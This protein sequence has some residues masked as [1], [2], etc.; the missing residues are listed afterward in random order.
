[1]KH[2]VGIASLVVACTANAGTE[3]W[4]KLP[5]LPEPNGGFMCAE[6]AGKVVVVGGTN[7]VNDEKRW[8]PV[9]NVFDPVAM[10]WTSLPSL[11]Q[12]LAHA[13]VGT[14][15]ERLVIAGGTT[16][17]APFTESVQFMPGNAVSQGKPGMAT[18]AVGAA[19]G[20]IGDEMIVV[21]GCDNIANLAAL[22]REAFA[23]NLRTGVERALPAYPAGPLG[24]TASVVN[25]DEVFVFGGAS[26]DAT[27]SQVINLTESHAYSP[28]T[29]AWRQLRSL[30][31]GV[32]ALSAV[33]LDANRFYLAG[34]FR[35]G[36]EGFTDKALIYHV[37]E[38]T[39][40]P[41]VALPYRAF[42][43]LV[44]CGGYVY[45]LGGEDRGKHRTD[46]VYRAKCA[47]LDPAASKR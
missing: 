26:W 38:D 14:V 21:G 2:A 23:W 43:G 3:I 40:T 45:C 32:R 9:V 15:G 16:G 6:W 12:P 10:R 30:P 37:S 27:A 4:Q 8:L 18:P 47:D 36:G 11:A 42:V 20:A 34:G 35:S 28:K 13:L 22:R 5:P 44:V 25:D 17:S 33:R 7:W 29:N 41:A 31:V 39:Y 46:E 24:I 1:M 19:G